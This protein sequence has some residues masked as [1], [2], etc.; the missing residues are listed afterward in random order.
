MIQLLIHLVLYYQSVIPYQL[1]YLRKTVW[2]V[3]K[4][5][6]SLWTSA[7]IILKFSYMK[8]YF[9]TSAQVGI[10]WKILPI[11]SNF[12]F[13]MYGCIISY[14]GLRTCI[15]ICFFLFLFKSHCHA[16]IQNFQ[17]LFPLYKHLFIQ[18]LHH[19]KFIYNLILIPF[20]TMNVC[21]ISICCL[22][23]HGGTKERS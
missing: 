7:C 9:S 16:I 15:S 21:V 4:I 17:K 14:N 18:R 8:V 10:T 12:Q 3:L 1:L 11:V 6:S 5:C 20:S 23:G 22:E 13:I 2:S 19:F